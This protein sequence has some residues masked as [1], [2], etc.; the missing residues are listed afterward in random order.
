M[1]LWEWM[2]LWLTSFHATV[3]K[4]RMKSLKMQWLYYW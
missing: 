2:N 4:H 1:T 3:S